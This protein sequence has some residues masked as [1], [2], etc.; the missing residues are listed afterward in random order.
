[1]RQ[2]FE[3]N[4]LNCNEYSTLH[5]PVVS[6]LLNPI[7]LH[8]CPNKKNKDIACARQSRSISI[9]LKL[10]FNA[11]ISCRDNHAAIEKE[12]HS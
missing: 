3:M 10:L 11:V 6:N 12:Q 8:S 9:V 1:M 7:V 4:E 5:I 2:F